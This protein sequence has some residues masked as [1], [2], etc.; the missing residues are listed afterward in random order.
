MPS[1][2]EV[3]IVSAVRQGVC[4]AVRTIGANTV[5]QTHWR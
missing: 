2:A 3:G 1:G 4:A 5:T